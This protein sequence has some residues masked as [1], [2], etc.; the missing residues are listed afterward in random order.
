VPH[1]TPCEHQVGQLLERGS[2]SRDHVELGLVDVEGIPCL[3]EQPAFD[4]MEIQLG[5][6]I[7]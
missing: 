6:A 2:P 7:V 3:D 1:G 5:D 4:A